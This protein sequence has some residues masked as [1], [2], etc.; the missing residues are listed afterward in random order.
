[1]LAER[2]NRVS[3]SPTQQV[4]I[5]AERLRRE[6]VDVVDFGAGEPDFATPAHVKAAAVAAIGDD[7]TKYTPNAGIGDLKQ[8]IAASYRAAYGVEYGPSETIV[9]AGGK[10][11]LFNA[12]LALF[13]PGD[14]VITHAPGWPT[15]IEQ[16]KLAEAKPVVVRTHP[17]D[18]F[19]VWPEAILSAITPRT[20]GIIL[21]SPGNPTGALVREEDLAAI[22]DEVASRDIWILADLCYEQLIYDRV[23]HN[24]P[25]VLVERMRDHTVLLGTLSKTYAMTGWRCGWVLGP[26][27]VIAA[28]NAIQSHS[29]SNVCSIT[30][31]AAVAALNGP[32][33][34]VTAML[35]EYRLRRD[36]LAEWLSADARF[37]FVMPAGA[38]YLFPDI[39]ELLSPDTIRTSGEFAQA[40]LSEAHVGVTAG[41]AFDAPGFLRISYATSTDRL[42]EGTN[43]MLAFVAALAGGKLPATASRR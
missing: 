5:A 7:F 17:E 8:A 22:A 12:A 9:T 20:R 41:E 36:K 26:A 18:G 19:R 15:I 1:M 40:L 11:A 25:T 6:G 29:T 30:Q 38:F 23:P 32:Q 2:A 16:I 14:E 43:R 35:D 3:A 10:Q 33:E 42:R 27:P 39:S 28:C 13:G 31:K 21:N 24:L 4:M 34:C 37:R